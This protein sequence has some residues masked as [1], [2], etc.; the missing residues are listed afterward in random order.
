MEQK[1]KKANT[2]DDKEAIIE[3]NIDG[4]RYIS[5]SGLRIKKCMAKFVKRVQIVN[6]CNENPNVAVD[7]AIARF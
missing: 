5:V 2:T 6:Y 3:V 7:E 1:S 4:K